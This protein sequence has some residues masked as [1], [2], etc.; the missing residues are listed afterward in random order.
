MKGRWFQR[1]L[2]YSWDFFIENV[3][4][5]THVSGADNVLLLNWLRRMGIDPALAWLEGI[6]VM[7]GS[8]GHTAIRF[9]IC[10]AHEFQLGYIHC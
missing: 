3:L 10:I 2:P 8:A 1:D 6:S 4:D 9:S 5:P 7:F